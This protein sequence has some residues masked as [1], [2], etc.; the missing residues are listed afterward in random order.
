[1]LK[2]LPASGKSTYARKLADDG[3][4]RVNKDDLRAMLHNGKWS[5]WNEEQVLDMRNAIIY[6]TLARGQSVVVDDTNFAIKHKEVLQVIARETGATFETKFFDVPVEE[7]IKRDLARPNSVGER[8]IRSM[9]NKYLKPAPLPS[10]YNPD[11]DDVIMCDIDGT[12]AHIDDRLPSPRSPYDWDR[13]G[14]DC[15]DGAVKWL[16]NQVF[17]RA[18]YMF[19]VSGRKELCREASEEWLSK[20][21]INY[22]KLFMRHSGDDRDDTIVKKE[23]YEKYI[24]D[25]Y[26][27]L[28]VLDDRN[29]VVDMWRQQGLKCLQVA[30]GDF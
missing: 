28:F 26:N 19:L 18:H 11:L 27:V 4:V 1:M 9:Y 3:Y 16:V 21:R 6:D 23:I 29:K 10:G 20:N 17:P 30:E 15:V 7:C 25:K 8:V 12:L 14:E 13:V 24:K 2:G 5:K 22:N